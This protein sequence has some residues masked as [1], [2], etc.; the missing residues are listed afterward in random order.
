VLT[1]AVAEQAPEA[2]KKAKLDAAAKAFQSYVD[3]YPQGE[4]VAEARTAMAR[5]LQAAGDTATATQVF[6]EMIA[7]PAS[8]TDL[9]LFEAGTNAFNANRREDAA[10]LFEAG[11]AKNPFYRDALYNLANTYM[12]L[13]NA[14]Q[15]RAAAERLVAVDPN[16]PDNWRL[17]AAAVQMQGK[18]IEEQAKAAQKDP[19]K[20]TQAAAL[21]KQLAAVNDTILL[22]FNRYDKATTRVQVNSFRH[23]GPQHTLSGSIE[24][25]G[26]QPKS[27]DLKVEFLDA[28]G[29]V[30]ATQTTKVEAAPK[31]K[32]DF[33]VEAN[34]EGIVAWRY[35]PLS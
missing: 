28:K 31:A 14:D 20:S 3:T 6:A 29:N 27:Y 35:A 22:H 24:N 11:L 30:V 1:L 13:K 15:M 7:S 19:K 4:N 33:R 2:E 23:D 16:Y 17:L 5:A 8:Y 32:A 12:A 10:K 34:A 21:R 9:Q 18:A 26:D 25:L